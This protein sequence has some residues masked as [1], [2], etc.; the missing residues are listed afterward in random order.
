[1]DEIL[2]VASGVSG[3]ASQAIKTSLH[4]VGAN[5]EGIGMDSLLEKDS[6]RK[7]KYKS[8]GGPRFAERRE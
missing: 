7:Y 8:N 2:I 6:M 1:L 3:P 5:W 4:V